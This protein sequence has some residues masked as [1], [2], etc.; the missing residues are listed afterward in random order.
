MLS[1]SQQLNKNKKPRKKKCRNCKEWFIPERDMQTTCSFNCAI[2]Y[3]K[4]NDVKQK[5]INKQKKQWKQKDK[6]ILR[7]KAQFWFNKF[8]RLRDKDLPCIS[9]GYDWKENG[10]MRQAHASHYMAVGKSNRLRFNEY[11]VHKSCSIC[12]SHLSG[13]LQEYRPRLINKIG[14]KK[15]EEL[16][17]IAKESK[18][19]KYTVEDYKKIILIYKEKCKEI[20]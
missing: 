2:K 13:N 4:N 6:S 20:E 14:L 17:E 5:E 12:N 18:P 16:E 11:N 9:C 7:E 19:C 1:K 3:A 8:I 10:N 15:V